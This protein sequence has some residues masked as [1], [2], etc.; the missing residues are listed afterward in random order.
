MIIIFLLVLG[1]ISANFH[2]F[3]TSPILDPSL[4]YDVLS[5]WPNDEPGLAIDLIPDFGSSAYRTTSWEYS[6]PLPTGDYY[7]VKFINWH[8]PDNCI[9]VVVWIGPN[10]NSVLTWHMILTVVPI[11][12]T[13]R[14]NSLIYFP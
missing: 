7:T 10:E 8:A 3:D 11:Q 6:R 13:L 14:S 4:A 1:A 2:V 12:L 5:F 9:K